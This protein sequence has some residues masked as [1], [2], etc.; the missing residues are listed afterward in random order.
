M[1]A[2]TLPT[3]SDT[4]VDPLRAPAPRTVEETGLPQ[5]FLVDLLCKILAQH[6]QMQLSELAAS[7][8]LPVSVLDAVLAP[9]RT[10]KLCEVARRGGSG[11]D[12]DLCF[13]LTE[14]GRL[15]A[16]DAA[17]RDAYAGP[18]PVAYA[19]YVAQVRRN[20]VAHKPLS[21]AHMQ[22][23][24]EGVVVRPALLDQLGAAFNSGRAIFMHG[25]A[26]SG[27]SYLAERLHGLL[28]GEVP[29]PHA[30]LIDGAV[31]PIYDPVV[32]PAVAEEAPA[33]SQF[34]RRYTR[35]LRWVRCQRPAVLT[36]GELTIEMLDLRFDHGARLY[37]APPHLKA[38]GGILVIDDLGRQRCSPVELM[39]R[40]IVPLDRHIDFLAL[41]NGYK[42]AVPFDMIVVFSSNLQPEELADGAFLRRL[43]Y[44]IHVGPLPEALYRTVFQ[45]VCER[46]GIAYDEALFDYLL[47]AH[48]GPED[49][50]LMACYP[51]DLLGQLCDLARYEGRQARL[52][53]AGLD[54]AWQN[55][56]GASTDDAGDSANLGE[57]K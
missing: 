14:F 52:D 2:T 44:K 5:L 22:R 49:R 20:S 29:I 28:E 18:A 43:G 6:G 3:S 47:R 37:Q 27:K 33:G 17:L 10:E 34:D 41:Q 32:H 1:L 53:Q 35:D 9:M 25:P 30:I 4:V 55:Y 8:K 15:R 39:N 51:N 50:P 54:W 12:A 42:F 11:T 36:G 24:Y 26:G 56:F 40:W 7:T 48:H 19:D 38:N 21:R 46:L 45:Q 31:V 16:Q 57:Q 13:N 23:V